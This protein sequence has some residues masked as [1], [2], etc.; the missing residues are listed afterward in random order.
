MPHTHTMRTIIAILLTLSFVIISPVFADDLMLT[1][2]GGMDTMGKKFNQW[3]YMPQ[4]AVLK[5]TGSK[6]ANIDVTVDGKFNTV[7]AN[8]AD[9]TWS[10][11]L[12]TLAVADHNIVVASGDQS[13]SF[14]LTIGSSPVVSQDTKGGLPVTGGELPLIGLVV[15]ASGLIFYGFMRKEV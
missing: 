5:G 3:W 15:V 10:F 12:G 9:G 13:Y 14:I 8:V 1:K 7:K 11:D 6:G 4:Q 2:I